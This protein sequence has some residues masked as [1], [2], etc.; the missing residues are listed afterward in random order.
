[1][2]AGRPKGAFATVAVNKTA[3]S[4]I[5]LFEAALKNFESYVEEE[6]SR[7]FSAIKQKFASV[8]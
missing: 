1:M 8:G 6:R 7:D 2:A 5:I 4:Y 3:K